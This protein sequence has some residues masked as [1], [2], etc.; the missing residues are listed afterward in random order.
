[1]RW[2]EELMKQSDAKIIDAALYK[3]PVKA[4]HQFFSIPIHGSGLEFINQILTHFSKIPYENISKIIKWQRYFNCPSAIRLPDEVME[5]YARQHFGGTC[6][7]L[8]FFLQTLLSYHGFVCYPVM[9]DMRWGNNVHCAL[10]LVYKGNKYLMDPGYLL[11]Q[12]LDL[13]SSNPRIFLTEHSGVELI[14]HPE[15]QFFEVYTFNRE[16]STWRYRFKDI[17]TAPDIFLDFWLSSFKWNSMH[18]LCLTKTEKGRL[19]YIHKYFMRET[20]F[21]GKTNY[22]IKNNYQRTIQKHFG[23][24]TEMV[25]E[26]LSALKVNMEKEK[27]LG[28]WV[29]RLKRGDY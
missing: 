27:K 1:M 12:L 16:K 5:G 29:P 10:I 23:I 18:G 3:E 11:N 4:F 19:L 9:A 28:L 2:A 20:T 7:S 25:E 22:N 13:D 8:T 26:A 6:F 14:Y 15:T 17:P 21:E 24:D